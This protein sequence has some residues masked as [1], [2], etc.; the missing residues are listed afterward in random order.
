MGI[1]K[2]S[3]LSLAAKK[4]HPIGNYFTRKICETSAKYP[5]DVSVDDDDRKSPPERY[6]DLLPTQVCKASDIPPANSSSSSVAS[7][8]NDEN[9]SPN[10]MTIEDL[11][12]GY[13]PIFNDVNDRHGGNARDEDHTPYIP[14]RFPVTHSSPKRKKSRPLEPRTPPSLGGFADACVDAILAGAGGRQSSAKE[15]SFAAAADAS[16]TKESSLSAAAASTKEE[17]CF[18]D[19]LIA[20]AGLVESMSDVCTQIFDD[21][22][23]YDIVAFNKTQ[24][25]HEEAFCAASAPSSYAKPKVSQSPRFLFCTL[26]PI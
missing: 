1:T 18:D 6:T 5:P 25:K 12:D 2:K 9:A 21:N 3:Q 17:C 14:S 22:P 20:D 19:E 7:T 8:I 23:C 24:R 4:C 11:H 26:H 15:C 16:T 10:K 13:H